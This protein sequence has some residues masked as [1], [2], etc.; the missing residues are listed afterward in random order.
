MGLLTALGLASTLAAPPSFANARERSLEDLV[1][2]SIDELANIEISSVSKTSEPLSDAPAAVYVIT[3]NDIIRSGATSMPEILRLA[4]NLQVARINANN[5]AISA[6]GFNGSVADKLLVLIDGRSVYAPF[7][8]GVFWDVQ[9][10]PPEN[11][12]RIEV[13]S[14]PGA[15]LWGAN[16]VNGVINI[17]SRK[18]GETQGGLLQV[19]AGNIERR[20]HAQYGGKLGESAAYRAYVNGA[21]Y[22]HGETAAGDNAKDGWFKQQSGFR[23]DWTP[24]GGD[25]VTVQGDV[26]SG[27]EDRLNARDLDIEGH[28]IL[29]RWS[30]T[31]DGGSTLQVQGYYDYF[32][33]VATGYAADYQHTY[34][35]DIQHSFALGSHQQI[36]WG[37][38]YRVMR[39]RFPIEPAYPNTQVFDPESSRLTLSNLFAQDSI[40]LTPALKLILGIKLEDGPYSA[41]AALP[42][43]RLSWKAT[44]KN[45]FWGAVSRAI[46]AP[47]RLD[48][49]FRQYDHDIVGL[50]GG[51]F[52][53]EKLTA[54]EIGYRS[55]PT[56]Q[57]S[58]SISTFYNVYDDLR[59][60][61]VAT[62]GVYAPYPILFQNS[63]EGE[64]Y[65]VETWGNYRV[66]DWWNLA[67]G[68][69]WLHKNLRYNNDNFF[70]LDIAGNDPTFQFF[71]RSSMD[72]SSALSLDFNLRKIDSLPAPASDSY[73]ELNARLG[74]ALSDTFD[75][76]LVGANLL[77]PRH[78][79]FGSESGSLRL[80]AIGTETQRSV[81]LDTRWR[82]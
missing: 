38:G 82:F 53:N 81:Y 79:E 45:L 14:G 31:L 52:K 70:G 17:I 4:P 76:A 18:S 24:A 13:I 39:D 6:R 35:L 73:V 28:N 27:A 55:Q 66:S 8:S 41:V 61:D 32:E 75:I 54:Y 37:G 64:T 23:V 63:M 62:E 42:N 69:S 10:V 65:G 78:E 9:D 25:L 7:Y 33:R 22:R 50:Q 29:A 49:D 60:F 34:D 26:Y 12:E 67:A 77:H 20:A 48:E 11:I 72:I 58:I 2:L 21:G 44:D 3:H 15:T 16:A 47:S 46:R 43:A 19:G 5:Y 36:V 71:L 40:A 51:D 68:Y 56:A 1:Q 74:W 30:H 57:L 59:S 80:G